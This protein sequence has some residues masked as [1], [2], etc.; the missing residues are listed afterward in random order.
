MNLRVRA[1]EAP[2]V[3]PTATPL[4]STRTTIQTLPSTSL[5]QAGTIQRRGNDN[6]EMVFVP[7][8]EFT[9]GSNQYDDEKPI[10]QVYLDAFWIDKHEVTNSQ[11]KAVCG[12]G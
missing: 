3:S 11:Y 10:H 8:G 6:A 1:P 7:K 5:L 12:C 2:N 4:P 9:M